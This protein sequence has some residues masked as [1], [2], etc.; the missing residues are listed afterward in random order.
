MGRAGK[1]TRRPPRRGHARTHEH[2]GHESAA[3]RPR[4]GQKLLLRITDMALDGD[5]IARHEGYVV[6]VPGAIPGEEVEAEVTASGRKYGR[7]RLLRVISPSSHR[8][9]PPCP[10]FG[11]CGGCAWQHIHYSEQLRMKEKL[12]AS[13]LGLALGAPVPLRPAVGLEDP[14]GFRSKVHFVVGR[15]DRGQA[16]LGHYAAHSRELIPVEE[17]RVH[18]ERGNRVAFALR[19]V[20]RRRQVPPVS[21]DRPGSGI[22]RHVVVRVSEKSGEAQAVLVATKRT[23]PELEEVAHEVTAGGG[24]SGFHLNIHRREGPMVL[25]SWTR[26]VAGRERLLEEVG[27]VRFLISPVSFFQTSIRS[28]EKLL[29][30]LLASIPADRSPVLDLY[31]GAGLFALPLARRG[32]RVL[33][34]EENAYAVDDGEESAELNRIHGVRYLRGR[35]EDEVRKLRRATF[36]TV[37]L[38]P[39]REGATE[40]VLHGVARG[41]R[42]ARIVYVSCDPR[43]LARDLLVLLS[44]GYRLESVTPVDMFPHTAHIESVAVLVSGRRELED[45]FQQAVESPRGPFTPRD[46][47]TPHDDFAPRER[48]RGPR[49]HRNPHGHSRKPRRNR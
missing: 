35:V 36:A 6:F 29:G 10:Y 14:W 46:H 20:L 34:V 18:S 27:G 32:H 38:D 11:P 21:E 41:L 33:C 43:A 1:T 39:P 48:R 16:V 15:D 9:A 44:A 37:I 4:I 5:A 45:G 13:A 12:L 28:A 3:G 23:F 49:P 19:D 7:A 25:G 26:R 30:V 31:A 22:A 47:L 42:P 2:E 24:A 8:V 17:C 40:T